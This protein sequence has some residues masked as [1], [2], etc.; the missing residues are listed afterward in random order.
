MS[1]EDGIICAYAFDGQGAAKP[2]ASPEEIAAQYEFPIDLVR[3]IATRVD[4][5]EYKRQQAAPGLK[6]TSKAFSV[7]RRFPIAQK[8]VI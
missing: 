5:N 7:G 4:R 8:Y 6:G 3:N 1:E 2:L